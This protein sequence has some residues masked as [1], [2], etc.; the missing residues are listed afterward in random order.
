MEEYY[1][2]QMEEACNQMACLCENPVEN[3]HR[4]MNEA[5]EYVV[6][7]G[8]AKDI[9]NAMMILCQWS[10]FAAELQTMEENKEAK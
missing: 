9:A 7:H 8:T 4:G 1:K 3:S 5:A 6:K 2:S 10:H